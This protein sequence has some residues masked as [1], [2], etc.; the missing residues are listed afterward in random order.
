V[1]GQ[2]GLIYCIPD[3]QD[4]VL[5]IDPSTETTFWISSPNLTTDDNKWAGGVLAPNGIIYGVPW[6]SL[7]VLQISTTSINNLITGVPSYAAWM[8]K[9]NFNK[10]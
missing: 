5:V 10:F 2:N 4:R 7:S 6:E 3:R 8:L 1:L 9:A